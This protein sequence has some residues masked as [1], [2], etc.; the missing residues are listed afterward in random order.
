MQVGVAMSLFILLDP[1]IVENEFKA[2]CVFFMST[3]AFA[4]VVINGTTAKY[5]LEGLGL[6]KMTQQ[7]LDVLQYVLKVGAAAA[8]GVGFVVEGSGFGSAAACLYRSSWTCCSI[9]SRWV[10]A[11]P[12]GLGSRVGD[13]F[14]LLLLLLLLLGWELGFRVQG[15]LWCCCCIV[16]CLVLAR[17]V[18]HWVSASPS[19]RHKANGGQISHQDSDDTSCAV[20]TFEICAVDAYAG[21]GWCHRSDP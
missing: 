7:Q 2:H 15:C 14:V 4:T 9:S 8:A 21:G 10:R 20:T 6:L 18:S 17:G 3:M 5:V 12:W 11:C 19:R 1:L 13:S 16:C